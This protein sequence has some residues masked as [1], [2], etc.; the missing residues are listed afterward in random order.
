MVT[1]N[2]AFEYPHQH[3]NP[4]LSFLTLTSP[5]VSFA[6]DGDDGD[7]GALTAAVPHAGLKEG[8]HL[9]G[10]HCAGAQ[11][12]LRLQRET[13]V[14]KN[15]SRG[16]SAAQEKASDSASQGSCDVPGRI[17]AAPDF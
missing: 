12:R 10:F 1:S 2:V 4:N 16:Q 3:S 9:C 17:T 5:S 6:D 7:Q 15:A 11:N 8:V 13:Q 14:N